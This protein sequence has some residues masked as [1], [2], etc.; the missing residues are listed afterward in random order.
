MERIPH[1]THVDEPRFVKLINEA[2]V[3]KDVAETKPWRKSSKDTAGAQKRRAKAERE[4]KKAEEAAKELGVYDEFFGDGK[5][6]KRK[7]DA[8]GD[9]E[10]S[11]AGM[12]PD[13]LTRGRFADTQ[14]SL[15]ALIQRRQVGRANVFSALEAKYASYEEETIEV[16]YT[17]SSAKKSKKGKKKGMEADED[18]LDD[19]AFEALQAKMFGGRKQQ[20]KS[21]STHADLD[22]MDDEAFKAL[23]AQMFAK[24]ARK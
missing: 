12:H 3:S 18:P 15:A 21:R 4:A 7:R 10:V 9:G 11:P 22:E 8:G 5:K 14:A 2:I 16:E 17:T 23:Q 24:K 6:G 13:L 20:T 19:A 1:S